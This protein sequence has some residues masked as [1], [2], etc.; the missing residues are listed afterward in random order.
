MKLINKILNE[1]NNEPEVFAS[2]VV[3]TYA[4]L[5]YIMAMVM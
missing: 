2:F 5:L 1:L 3:V 4:L